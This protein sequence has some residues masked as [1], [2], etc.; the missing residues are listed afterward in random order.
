MG[1]YNVLYPKLTIYNTSASA[2]YSFT[3]NTLDSSAQRDFNLRSLA[4]H[5][6]INED[7]G[8]MTFVIDD[9]DN[10]MSSNGDPLIEEQMG[11]KLELGSTTAGLT[12]WFYGIV[13]DVEVIETRTNITQLRITCI[14]WSI[15]L[16]DRLTN[17]VR[18]Q[19]KTS[20][21]ETLDA[22]DTDAATA[23]IAKEIITESDH[24]TDPFFPLET[25]ITVNGV[26]LTD[27]VNLMPE[28][29]QQYQTFASTLAHL[30]A[31]AGVV[32]GLDGDRDMFFRFMESTNSGLM[33][34]NDIAHTKV[35]THDQDKVCNLLEDQ[36]IIFRN[37]SKDAG[38]SIIH[39]L[40]AQ[41]NTKDLEEAVEDTTASCD[42]KWYGIPFVP[43]KQNISKFALRMAKTGNPSSGEARFFI[44]NQA[45]AGVPD[46]NSIIGEATLSQD[47]LRGLEGSFAWK[48][49]A[50]TENVS[51]IVGT[52]YYIVVKIYGN[53][54]DTFV[55]SY[56]QA[57]SSSYED[58]AD[59]SSWTNRA[60][61]TM[62]HR[63][64][65]SEPVT[66]TF[67]DVRTRRKFR[68]RE[69]AIEFQS[70]EEYAHVVEALD[71]LGDVVAV[72][73]R[74]YNPITVSCPNSRIDVGK[75][76][77]LRVKD[78][79]DRKVNIIGLDL[80]ING[81]VGTDR[82]TLDIQENIT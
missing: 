26:D 29:Q 77:R 65:Y 16:I 57:G 20:D 15:R 48:E 22:T 3:A 9:P 73:K 7:L 51:I 23:Q 35:T 56:D 17:I 30:S 33:L 70:G 54:T 42:L 49:I 75:Y 66:I 32:Y 74:E 34:T 40:N 43:T 4:L 1:D 63:T 14:N 39:G 64:Y 53:A 45:A 11:V 38:I 79:F 76:A 18:F 52:T 69:K 61:S 78:K 19:K 2:I 58:S 36:P 13:M 21:G 46:M 44:V 25:E 47:E 62:A 68:Y 5:L 60:T 67:E 72:R 10:T 37:T 6:G 28:I 59:G 80:V 82:L 71:F 12:S 41:K 50:L 81:D 24:L 31:C 8:A 27:A 55:I